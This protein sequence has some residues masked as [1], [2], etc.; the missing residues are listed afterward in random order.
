MR[1]F[2]RPQS[3]IKVPNMSWNR[4]KAIWRQFKRIVKH[5]LCKL[6]TC[7]SQETQGIS[8]EEMAVWQEHQER[9]DQDEHNHLPIKMSLPK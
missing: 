4:I 2:F 7:K 8:G 5:L 3:K 1:P 9:K 6:L